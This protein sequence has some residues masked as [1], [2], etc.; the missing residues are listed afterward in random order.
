MQRYKYE[1][2][3]VE[4]GRH[5]QILRENRNLTQSELANELSN[6]S[7]KSISRELLKAWECGTRKLKAED[8]KV[9]CDYFSVSSDSILGKF[10]DDLPLRKA[11]LSGFAI[12][13]ISCLTASAPKSSRLLN[14]ILANENLGMMLCTIVEAYEAGYG[15]EEIKMGNKVISGAV[16]AEMY[17]ELAIADFRKILTE[18]K[19]T[20]EGDHGEH[21]E[22]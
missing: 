8:L 19:E 4:L 6:L 12:A 14:E 7:N 11:G 3:D 21:S 17:F 1:E 16:L 10:A 2:F 22:D 9:L 18:I 13:E 20:W 5:I 15:G